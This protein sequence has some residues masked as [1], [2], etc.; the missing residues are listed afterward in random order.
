MRDDGPIPQV[1][2][3]AQ[4]N[5]QF[6][7]DAER[8]TFFDARYTMKID[9]GKFPIY[10]MTHVFYSTPVAGPLR[11]HGMLQNLFEICMS[12]AKY[13]DS[14]AEIAIFQYRPEKGRK[15]SAVNSLHKKKI[16]NEMRMNVQIG[17]YDVDSV[18]LYLFLD[19]NILMKQ[20]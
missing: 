8:D 3:E 13:T 2:L 17:D 11:K 7:M 19:V 14:L 20:T 16:G 4:N 9:M 6:D 5:V 12:L 18:I 1:Q 15:G 10:E